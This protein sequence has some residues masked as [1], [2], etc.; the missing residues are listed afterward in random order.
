MIVVTKFE[1]GS[2]IC[3]GKVLPPNIFVVLNG[4]HLVSFMNMGVSLRVYDFLLLC[5]DIYKIEKK[6]K[7]KFFI[8]VL[9]KI[10]SLAPM[11]SQ[12]H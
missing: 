5:W 8:R 9:D 10:V 2:Q 7:N 6:T 11:Y 1:F 4:N 12:V 3:E